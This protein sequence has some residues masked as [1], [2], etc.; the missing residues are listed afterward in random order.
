MET[1]A[2]M[3]LQEAQRVIRDPSVSVPGHMMAAGV[4]FESGDSTL[5]GLLVCARHKHRNIAWMG[6]SALHRRTGRPERHDEQGY[7][8]IDADDWESYLRSQR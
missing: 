3:T 6:A 2:S 5:D 7:L 4:L 1:E 8:A